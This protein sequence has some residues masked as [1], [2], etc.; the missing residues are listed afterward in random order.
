MKKQSYI[1]STD[2]CARDHEC[3]TEKCSKHDSNAAVGDYPGFNQYQ[4]PYGGNYGV[5]LPNDYTLSALTQ[6]ETLAL[7][8][9]F[10]IFASVKTADAINADVLYY[11]DLIASA[12][13]Q[14]FPQPISAINS[15]DNTTWAAWA[16][17]SEGNSI[18][19][20][21]PLS[22]Q[23]NAIPWN[24]ISSIPLTVNASLPIGSYSLLIRCIDTKGDVYSKVIYSNVGYTNAT[25]LD[26]LAVVPG[27]VQQGTFAEF[28]VKYISSASNAPIENASCIYR[29]GA[30]NTSMGYSNG[31]YTGQLAFSQAQTYTLDVWCNQS[32]YQPGYLTQTIISN[33]SHCANGYKDTGETGVD[34]GGDCSPCATNQTPQTGTCYDGIKNQGEYKVDCG[35]PCGPCSI[36]INDNDCA[37]D[38][39]YYCTMPSMACTL[40]NCSTDA[41]CHTLNRWY[42]NVTRS[43]ISKPT[44]CNTQAHLCTLAGQTTGNSTLAEVAM[45]IQPI[46]GIATNISG[47]I[48]YVSNCEDANGGLIINTNSATTTYYSIDSSSN[49]PQMGTYAS[50]QL[51]AG[52]MSKQKVALIPEL[53]KANR[54]GFGGI[55]GHSERV[56]ARINLM[57]CSGDNKCATAIIDAVSFRHNLKNSLGI[58][59]AETSTGVSDYNFIFNATNRSIAVWVKDLATGDYVNITTGYLPSAPFNQSTING[60][61]NSLF[62]IFYYQVKTPEGEEVEGQ[63]GHPWWMF[64]EFDPNTMWFKLNIPLYAWMI[65]ILIAF[66]IAALAY[67][68]YR[69]QRQPPTQ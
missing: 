59:M 21:H 60:R 4:D 24:Y 15:S 3:F 34:C 49:Y 63:Y 33:P 42:S 69:R 13:C 19:S 18:Y 2:R 5:C 29:M 37:G 30:G 7:G 55:P 62:P 11:K 66:A 38:G 26:F 40:N 39:S 12:N 50:R 27:S 58:R 67:M 8:S 31:A 28:S 22:Y 32:T 23:P 17:N 41:D 25:T 36:C 65:W 64:I 20:Y 43:L 44:I 47:T 57:S 51:F 16:Y 52:P 35:G 6:P 68:A 14:V 54:D 10:S 45:D 9:N 48:L 1:V 61:P 46:S 53:C 56:Y